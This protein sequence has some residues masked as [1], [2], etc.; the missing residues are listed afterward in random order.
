MFRMFRFPAKRANEDHCRGSLSTFPLELLVAIF[1]NIL[2]SYSLQLD[3]FLALRLVC[4]QWNGAID[5]AMQTKMFQK[6]PRGMR[7]RL[8][9]ANSFIP[10]DFYFPCN[11]VTCSG[12]VIAMANSDKEILIS[13]LTTN[14]ME[15]TTLLTC[16]S[17]KF[18]LMAVGKNYIAAAKERERCWRGPRKND[19]KLPS[20]I[21]LYVW[22]LQ[23]EGKR[24]RREKLYEV[25][26]YELSFVD[27]ILCATS[28]DDISYIW[29]VSQSGARTEFST[30]AT[31]T[32]QVYQNPP[33]LRS[34]TDACSYRVE[35][36]GNSWIVKRSTSDITVAS[37]DV[38]GWWP[39]VNVQALAGD[40]WSLGHQ[41][42]AAGRIVVLFDCTS[43][44]L[45]S[46]KADDELSCWGNGPWWGEK[47]VVCPLWFWGSGKLGKGRRTGWLHMSNVVVF[48]VEPVT[49]VVER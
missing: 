23:N 3:N 27:D 49:D 12:E 32:W 36:A 41:R 31:S 45:S 26:V 18:Q 1:T 17:G 2:R 21:E 46:R 34:R 42:S 24:P 19:G 44:Q 15:R 4:R 11:S 38:K 33:I 22:P 30:I 5:L 7:L 39:S 6:I 28:S 47:F 40:V 14:A 43:L 37:L 48:K 13:R 35:V 29:D 16:E 20:Y 9:G 8:I 25:E 10:W